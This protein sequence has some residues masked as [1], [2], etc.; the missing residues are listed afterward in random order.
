M[1]VYREIAAQL[2]TKRVPE[3]FLQRVID[4]NDMYRSLVL[5]SPWIDP[6]S[7]QNCRL[8]RLVSKIQKRQI[9]TYVF[10][11]EPEEKWHQEAVNLLCQCPTLEMNFNPLLHAKFFVCEC[12]PHGFALLATSN[13]TTH[14]LLGYEVGLLIEGRGGG[15]SIVNRLRDLGLVTLRA[16]KETKRVKEIARVGRSPKS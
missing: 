2:M 15:E 10:T 8:E 13:L 14:G 12:I 7:G 11:R 4:G 9:R 3:R 16:F 6:M 5:V 1:S